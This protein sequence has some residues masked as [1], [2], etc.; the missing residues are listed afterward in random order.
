MPNLGA[1]NNMNHDTKSN[2]YR[3]VSLVASARALVVAAV[4]LLSVRALSS[5][6]VA[7]E[8]TDE[9]TRAHAAGD[10]AAAAALW[11]A[12][13]ARGDAAAQCNLGLLFESGLGVEQ[14]IVAAARW[15]RR[16]AVKGIGAAQHNL[17]AL[18]V[19]DR[20]AEALF[21][22]EILAASGDETLAASARQAASSIAGSVPPDIAR[23]ARAQR[24][25]SGRNLI[26]QTMA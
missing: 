5:D 4:C 12:A 16:A 25:G 21:W 6:V 14:D 18:I 3:I 2:Q 24:T 26:P 20:P 10:Y 17:A 15:Y 23:A 8:A 22:L 1:M 13:A 19:A 9:A 7:E 11:Q